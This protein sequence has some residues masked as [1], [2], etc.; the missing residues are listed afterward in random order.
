MKFK[1]VLLSVALAT[2]TLSSCGK[3]DEGPGIS[4][5]SKKARI[6]NTWVVEG[7]TINGKETS[8]ADL[9]A[10]INDSDTPSELEFTKDGNVTAKYKDNSTEK[11]KWELLDGKEKIKLSTTSGSVSVSV[12]AKIIKLK[13]KSM[14]IED[15][16]AGTKT[17]TKYKEK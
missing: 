7:E 6:A 15:E 13:E 4:L 1:I 3:Y 10:S 9:Q 11:Y 14:W 12:E 8:A 16:S 5:R 17:L 2:T